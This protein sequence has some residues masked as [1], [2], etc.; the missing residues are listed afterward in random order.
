MSGPR[1]EAHVSR[2][3][4]RRE[5]QYQ[6]ALWEIS[7]DRN[8]VEFIPG[9]NEF[10]SEREVYRALTIQTCFPKPLRKLGLIMNDTRHQY[11][12][13]SYWEGPEHTPPVE[14]FRDIYASILNQYGDRPALVSA[15]QNH[16]SLF[17]VAEKQRHSGEDCLRYTFRDLHRHAGQLASALHVQGLRPRQ[18]LATFLPNSAQFAIC[19]LA[20]A[21]LNV[22]LVPMDVRSLDRIDEVRHYLSV[23]KPDGMIV[24]DEQCALKFDAIR[25]AGPFEPGV[26]ILIAGVSATNEGWLR[27]TDFMNP[28]PPLTTLETEISQTDPALIVFTSGTSGLPKACVLSCKNIASF[29]SI[30][31]AAGRRAPGERWLQHFPIS[32]IGGISTMLGAWAAGAC[33]VI[34]S[35]YFDAQASLEAIELESCTRMLAVPAVV[36]QLLALPTFAPRRVRSLEFVHVGATMVSPEVLAKC[37]D[38]ACFGA[39][40]ALPA[41][42]MT[43]ALALLSWND[44]DEPI[45]EQ[46]FASIGKPNPGVK[47]KICPPGKRE[48]SVIGDTGELHFST[49]AL[50]PGY[51]GNRQEG[52]YEEGGNRWFASGDQARMHASGAVFILGRYKDVIVRGGEKLSPALVEHCIHAQ[53]PAIQV[54]FSSTTRESALLSLP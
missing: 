1:R 20:A 29:I 42:G 47:I 36:D 25:G 7:P 12:G 3:T 18:S 45:V 16:D 32:H 9:F 44:D 23:V 11:G 40:N 4:T 54:C 39:R 6:R 31:K 46:G 24:S 50:T 21:I 43:E 28:P 41:Y 53:F 14:S 17:T 51:L 22:A 37:K 49:P 34:P 33:L 8:S 48:C 26:K 2:L 5:R 35:P 19:L 15:R 10:E 38:P 27:L 52:F 30:S 13:L